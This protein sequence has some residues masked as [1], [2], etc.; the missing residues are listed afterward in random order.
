MLILFKRVIKYKAVHGLAP[1]YIFEL[2]QLKHYGRRL[3]LEKLLTTED[4]KDHTQ[5]VWRCCFSGTV[6]N[7]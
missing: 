5:I 6:S 1:T 3:R 4:H 2:I 7:A